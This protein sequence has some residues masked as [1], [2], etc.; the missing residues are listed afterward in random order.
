[1]SSINQK[2]GI[3]VF[4][5]AMALLFSAME[6]MSET[7]GYVEENGKMIVV[8]VNGEPVMPRPLNRY[9]I[10]CNLVKVSK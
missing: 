6:A 9:D 3:A 7:I 5:L 1:M 2:Y 10:E 8:E 4:V